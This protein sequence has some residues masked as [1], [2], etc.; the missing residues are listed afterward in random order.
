MKR[1][2]TILPFLLLG[3]VVNVAVAWGYALWS[4]ST[5]GSPIG[6]NPREDRAW[7]LDRVP[8][9]RW[10]DWTTPH[11][12]PD[13]GPGFELIGFSTVSLDPTVSSTSGRKGESVAAIRLRSGLPLVSLE[14]SRWS[15]AA[16]ATVFG[17]RSPRT[18]NSYLNAAL[19]PPPELRPRYRRLLPLRPLPTGFAVNTLFY[20]TILWLL[21]PGPFALRRFIRR[22]RGQCPACGYPA[23]ESAVCS[24]CG[25]LMVMAMLLGV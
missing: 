4:P 14:G 17:L 22:K 1:L 11:I 9:P 24:E 13:A 23:G 16:Y 15:K 19:E 8:P 3:A 2:L 20:A 21:I 7:F 25:R 12:R 5:P 6:S 10:T 18:P